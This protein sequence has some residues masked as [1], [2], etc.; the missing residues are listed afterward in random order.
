MGYQKLKFPCMVVFMD[1]GTVDPTTEV[2]SR[3]SRTNH[4]TWVVM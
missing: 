3:E 4:L 1:E 2:L